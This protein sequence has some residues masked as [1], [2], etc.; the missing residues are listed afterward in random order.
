[1]EVGDSPLP[2]RFY[3]DYLITIPVSERPVFKKTVYGLEPA[4]EVLPKPAP[5]DVGT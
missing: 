4:H 3:C 5:G 2:S 1:M